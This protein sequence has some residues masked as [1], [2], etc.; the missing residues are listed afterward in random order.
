M[1][2]CPPLSEGIG[3]ALCSNHKNALEVVLSAWNSGCRKQI[4]KKN[5]RRVRLNGVKK[6]EHNPYGG[7]IRTTNCDCRFP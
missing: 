4:N 6:C 5:N 1:G 7:R 3:P 2:S